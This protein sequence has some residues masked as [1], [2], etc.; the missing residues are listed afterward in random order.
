MLINLQ[1]CRIAAWYLYQSLASHSQHGQVR[2]TW[3]FLSRFRRGRYVALIFP[4]ML[5]PFPF[6]DLIFLGRCPRS[7]NYDIDMDYDLQGI[8]EVED[9]L[10]HTHHTGGHPTVSQYS[11]HG[12]HSHAP[13]SHGE[14]IMSGSDGEFHF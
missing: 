14:S 8:F 2:I 1:H 5:F 10:P 7:S 11:S 4:K 12:G 13:F 3:R 9:L 6:T